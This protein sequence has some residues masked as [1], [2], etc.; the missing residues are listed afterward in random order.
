MEVPIAGNVAIWR[1]PPGA[2]AVPQPIA[3]DPTPTSLD[4]ASRG[5]PQGAYTT[6]RTFGGTAVLRL[7][8]HLA[9]LEETARLSGTEVYLDWPTIRAA[10]HEAMTAFD[11]PD[12]RVRLTLDTTREPGTIYI[13]L[14]PLHSPTPEQYEHGVRVV[15]RQLQR[16]NPKAKSTTFLASAGEIRRTLPEG[17]HEAIMVG[18]DGQ[19][20]EGLSSNFFAIRDR[21]LWTAEEGVLSG[22][23]RALVLEEAADE[24]LVI[25]LEG[26]PVEELLTIDEAF[27]TSSGRAVLPVV[28]I[29]GHPIGRGEPGP[30]TRR[31]L[32]RYNARVAREVEVL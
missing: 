25:H 18:A 13:S 27:I 10:L 14:E 30:I 9:R 20:L 2:G 1:L 3:V 8:E 29:D 22:I 26:L 7:D 16:K 23:T 24:G 32:E 6:L 17:C 19:L 12:S 21:D 4:E 5:L 15:T 28:E 31:L 11:T